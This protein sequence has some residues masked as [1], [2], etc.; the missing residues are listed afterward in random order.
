MSE[1]RFHRLGSFL[2]LV[3]IDNS[4]RAASGEPKVVSN[5]RKSLNASYFLISTHH[6]S[7][8]HSIFMPQCTPSAPN[9]LLLYPV[10][11][12]DYGHRSAVGLGVPEVC[13]GS[14]P[15]ESGGSYEVLIIEL[16]YIY[17]V[18]IANLF[19]EPTIRPDSKARSLVS[20]VEIVVLYRLK[21]V[22][23]TEVEL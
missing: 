10:M 15:A 20:C 4:L 6:Y 9:I 18:F 17:D 5:R 22:E 19:F 11:Q 3:M 16:N 14:M 1:V 2:I 23:A 21:G 13:S 12:N 7:C 8:T